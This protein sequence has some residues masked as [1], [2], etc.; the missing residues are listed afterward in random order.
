M[1][2]GTALP[3]R[4]TD[5][6]F[7]DVARQ[8]EDLGYG[9]LSVYDHLVPLGAP[10]G[11]PALEAFTTLAAAAAVTS[12]VR[13]VTLVAR[14]ALRPPAL[15]AHLARSVRAVAGERFVLGLG[16]GDRS[17][18]REDALLGR[19]P[20]TPA[21]REAAVRATVAAVRAAVP[22][23]AVWIGGTGPT[24]RRLAAE[25]ADGWNGWGVP[26]AE[27]PGLPVTLTW[28]GQVALAPTADAAAGL[29]AGW[30][31]G[32]DPAERDRVLSGTP[33]DVAAGLRE[34][35]ASGVA[36]AYL[37]FVGRD[38]PGQR[39]LFARAVLP[40]LDR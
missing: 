14:A 11:T 6:A 17:S 28:A 1:I 21:E 8:C 30:T 39:E 35:A 26:A 32:R 25:L 33:D 36:E 20:L 40:L 10:V 2:V 3:Q 23:L 24:A 4:R 27:L 22:G 7:L 5:P 29:V 31:P 15:T 38:V 12:R 37:S 13:L 19:S 18:D 34:L 16:L 9:G